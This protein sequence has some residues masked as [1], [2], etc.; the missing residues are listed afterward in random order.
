MFSTQKPAAA[1]RT[2]TLKTA[3]R[4]RGRADDV[5]HQSEAEAIV[6]ELFAPLNDERR[7][8]WQQNLAMATEVASMVC[9]S[10]E[11][12]RIK[13]PEFTK[14]LIKEFI[15]PL[16]ENIFE[17]M[18]LNQQDQS[19]PHTHQFTTYDMR[20]KNDC[21]VALIKL[22]DIFKNCDVDKLLGVYFQERNNRPNASGENEGIVK[23]NDILDELY[24]KNYKPQSIPDF[25]A[26]AQ[27]LMHDA[28]VLSYFDQLEKELQR[29]AS[30]LPRDQ[31]QLARVERKWALPIFKDKPYIRCKI[32]SGYL[33][34]WAAENDFTQTA[35]LIRGVSE[36]VFSQL[37]NDRTLIKDDATNIGEEHGV[38]SHALQWYLIIEHHKKTGFLS[39]SPLSLYAEFSAIWNEIIDDYNDK[40]F[41]SPEH[42]TRTMKQFNNLV[43][44]PLLAESCNRSYHK[45]SFF[46]YTTLTSNS[47]RLAAKHAAEEVNGVVVRKFK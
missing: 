43:R 19:R 47:A 15:L 27:F 5:L 35:K 21:A 40:N 44:W 33:Y 24:T 25:M 41:F 28:N 9:R 42:L 46:D 2:S 14:Y 29:Y 3:S 16:G 37:L 26:I 32:L 20:I 22:L 18:E 4:K 7:H 34:Q 6:A 38:W 1:K 45:I 36:D 10:A 11:R 8:Y 17:Q 31:H 12:L 13:D 39:N 23:L 30:N